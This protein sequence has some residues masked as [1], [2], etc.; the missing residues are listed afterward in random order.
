MVPLLVGLVALGA[1]GA[2]FEELWKWSDLDDAQN[3]QDFKNRLKRFETKMSL[4]MDK[5]KF[6]DFFSKIYSCVE[7]DRLSIFYEM[8]IK[9]NGKDWTSEIVAS[10]TFD[11]SEAPT[12][13][14]ENLSAEKIDVTARYEKNL[15]LNISRKIS[16]KE[17]SDRLCG[18]KNLQDFET[19]FKDSL[20]KVPRTMKN[21]GITD[22]AIRLF[23]DTNDKSKGL[24]NFMR[25][26]HKLHITCILWYKK[27]SNWIE[28][29]ITCE[30]DKMKAPTWATKGLSSTET[31]VTDRYEK[32]LQVCIK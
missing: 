18:A 21:M 19:R 22:Y 32:Y 11:E 3:W 15:N 27:D 24:F 6:A 4:F 1:A 10:C 8:H 26:V 25:P 12:W 5:D 31:D 13:A 29:H 7:G 23:S 28:Q 9:E 16:L 20:N 14:T 17:L 30:F 2:A